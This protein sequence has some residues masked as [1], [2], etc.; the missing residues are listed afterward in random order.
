[1]SPP[2]APHLLDH[3][4]VRRHDLGME[5]FVIRLVRG[6]GGNLSGSGMEPGEVHGVL[7]RVI[8]GSE[9]PFGSSYELIELLQSPL[10]DQPEP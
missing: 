3:D 7:S 4:D 1:V 6:G 10:S 9:H 8:D 5:T 2:G